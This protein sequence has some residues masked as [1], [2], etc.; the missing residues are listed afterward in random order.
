MSNDPK[1]RKRPISAKAMAE[2]A[3]ELTKVGLK[4]EEI[5]ASRDGVRIIFKRSAQTKQSAADQWIEDNA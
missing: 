2:Y 5:V 4:P 3:S 1:T